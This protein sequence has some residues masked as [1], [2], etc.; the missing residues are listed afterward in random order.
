[1]RNTLKISMNKNGE[2]ETSLPRIEMMDERIV[3]VPF[4]QLIKLKIKDIQGIK[5]IA[6]PDV[7]TTN[8]PELGGFR[9]FEQISSNFSFEKK[10]KVR[11]CCSIFPPTDMNNYGLWTIYH[12]L[13]QRYFE[14]EKNIIICSP[15]ISPFKIIQKN[16]KASLKNS[17]RESHHFSGISDIVRVEYSTTGKTFQQ[18]IT[19]LYKLLMKADK[20][21]RFEIFKG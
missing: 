3:I 20:K 13:L 9:K 2:I 18:L 16:Y 15:A 8:R 1:M 4:D 21:V 5:E 10:G 14:T 7:A 6:V 17:D 11:V 12:F 19:E